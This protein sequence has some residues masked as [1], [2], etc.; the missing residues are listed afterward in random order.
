MAHGNNEARWDARL[1]VPK[2][3][4]RNDGGGRSRWCC[5]QAASE[6]RR[7]SIPLVQYRRQI[8]SRL[9]GHV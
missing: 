1:C 8:T 6:H 3:A 7:V 4:T 2:L 9:R 5:G